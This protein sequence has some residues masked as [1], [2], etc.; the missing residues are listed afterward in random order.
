ME[1]QTKCFKAEYWWLYTLM[2]SG[3]IPSLLDLGIGG[4]SLVQSIPIL[5]RSLHTH[6][7]DG[8]AVAIQERNWVSLVLSVQVVAGICLG[9]VAQFILLPWWIFGYV[10]PGLGLGVFKFAQTIEALNLPGRIF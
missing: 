6:L 10:L 7:P 5:S 4:F 2:L 8:Q 1:L 3:M 9:F